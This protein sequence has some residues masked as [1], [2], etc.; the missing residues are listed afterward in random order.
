MKEQFLLCG[1]IGWGMEILWTGFHALCRRDY[2]LTGQSSLWMFPIYGCAAVIGPVSRRLSRMP[3]FFRGSLY[4]AGI[5]AAEYSTGRLLQRFAACPWDYS[6]CPLNYRGVI[7]FDYAPIWF[8]TGLFFEKIL[9]D[10]P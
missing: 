4:A 10:K 1:G 5:F 3:V 9:A 7:R 6:G 2:T 8:F